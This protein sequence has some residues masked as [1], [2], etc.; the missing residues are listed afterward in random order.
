M[1]LHGTSCHEW[2]LEHLYEP[3]SRPDLCGEEWFLPDWLCPVL[4]TKCAPCRMSAQV[5]LTDAQRKL[6][7]YQVTVTGGNLH[8]SRCYCRLKA[9]YW[10][11]CLCLQQCT[12]LLTKVLI[13]LQRLI[14]CLAKTRSR[15]RAASKTSGCDEL[16]VYGV[17]KTWDQGSGHQFDFYCASHDSKVGARSK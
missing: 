11:W 8:A 4:A 12:S 5:P 7:G 6:G 10:Y 2:R 16:R 9:R 15:T 1:L 14:N 13:H 3:T 17:I